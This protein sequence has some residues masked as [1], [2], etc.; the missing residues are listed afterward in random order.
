ML[1]A[2]EEEFL[3]FHTNYVDLSSVLVV[4]VVVVRQ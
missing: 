4:E 2:R 1:E 3:F